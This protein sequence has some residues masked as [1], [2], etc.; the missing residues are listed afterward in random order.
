VLV[1]F[2][3]RPEASKMAPVVHA[4]AR[5]PLLE[6]LVLVTGQ[7]REQLDRMME[8][9]ELTADADLDVMRAGQTPS[10]AF[11][12]IL[13]AAA[14]ALRALQPDYV[15]VHGDTT[16]TAALALAAFYE[17][18][19]VAHVE[20]GLRSFDLRQPFPEEANRR[21]TDVVTDLDLPPTPLA[22]SHLLREGKT[23]ERMVVT[24]QTAIDAVRWARRRGR[25][26]ADVP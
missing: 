20:A 6:P 4:L 10:E 8:V 14:R 3:T 17:S 7:H 26:P 15:L 13:P 12:R 21:L 9:F 19:P 2:G 25:R 1:G 23:P 24:G 5:H 22:R 18:F 16:T 11:G